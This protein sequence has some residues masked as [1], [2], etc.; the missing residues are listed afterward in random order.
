MN[1]DRPTLKQVVLNRTLEANE[2]DAM[3]DGVLQQARSVVG[4]AFLAR[5]GV[6][7]ELIGDRA[8]YGPSG[9]PARNR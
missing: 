8:G 9:R 1:T 6:V 4:R 3:F 5:A 7:A 2:S